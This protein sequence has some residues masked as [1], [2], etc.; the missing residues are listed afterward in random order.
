MSG[1]S[2]VTGRRTL[3]RAIAAETKP[4]LVPRGQLPLRFGWTPGEALVKGELDAAF[5]EPRK[6]RAEDDV[7]EVFGEWEGESE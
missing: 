3:R 7:R 6:W 1:V 2:R 5:E 4:R